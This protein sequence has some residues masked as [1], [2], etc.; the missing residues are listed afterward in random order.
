M[1]LRPEHDDATARQALA[2]KLASR[3][4]VDLIDAVSSLDGQLV[5][6]LGKT[7]PAPGR[8]GP[9]QPQ[10]AAVV[11]IRGGVV[12]VLLEVP[13]SD[14][15]DRLLLRGDKVVVLGAK[16]AVYDA[17]SGARAFEVASTHTGS[18]NA[19]VVDDAGST[20]FT[21]GADGGVSAWSLDG[22]RNRFTTKVASDPLRAIAF[23]SVQH[24][25]LV[26]GW[27]DRVHALA[28]ADGA[29]R[30][31]LTLGAHGESL[32]VSGDGRHVLV[33]LGGTRAELRLYEGA[34]P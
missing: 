14:A 11:A 24:R 17:T 18:I 4:G 19:A 5:V 9:P 26:T 32:A 34:R 23:D 27:D 21:A 29:D 1:L 15:P 13:V 33:G 16:I 7:R 8:S 31:A 3:G 30:G 25:L 22:G 20:L 2:A 10:R 6:A 12:T 28:A